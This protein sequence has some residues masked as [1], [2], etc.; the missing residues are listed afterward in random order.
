[1]RTRCVIGCLNA[2]IGM[3]HEE[4]LAPAIFFQI[5]IHSIVDRFEKQMDRTIAPSPV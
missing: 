1:M 5:L 3:R 4:Q 2:S